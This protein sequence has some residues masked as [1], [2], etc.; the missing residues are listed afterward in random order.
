MA[1]IEEEIRVP[2]TNCPGQIAA[3]VRCL[4]S[5]TR[6]RYLRVAQPSRYNGCGRLLRNNGS[7]PL[8][9]GAH[10]RA[11]TRTHAHT[12]AHTRTPTHMPAREP[13]RKGRNAYGG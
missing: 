1:T 4:P 13:T 5:C 3:H 2:A 10:T 12:R 7:P 6:P 8:T 11:H 9:L